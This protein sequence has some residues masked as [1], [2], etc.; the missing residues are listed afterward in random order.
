MLMLKEVDELLWKRLEE[1][2]I[3]PQY[4][5]FRWLTLMLSQEFALPEVL[6]LWDALF[7]DTQRFDFLLDICVAMLV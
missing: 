1:L 5:S 2:E 6:R 3:K 7:S 4:Y